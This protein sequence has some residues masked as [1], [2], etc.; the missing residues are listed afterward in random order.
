M[1]ASMSGKKGRKQSAHITYAAEVHPSLKDA[2][3]NIAIYLV[4]SSQV[5]TILLQTPIDTQKTY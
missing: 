1:I 4:K 2:G 5:N 3:H